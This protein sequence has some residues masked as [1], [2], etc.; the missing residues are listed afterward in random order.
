MTISIIIGSNRENS[1]SARVGRF[2]AQNLKKISDKIQVESI[3]LYLTPLPLFDNTDQSKNLNVAQTALKLLQSDALVVISPE[4]KGSIPPALKNFFCMFG[5]AEFGHKPGLIVGVSSGRGGAF[6]VN[7]LRSTNYKNNHICYIPEQVI[8][9]QINDLVLDIEAK[10]KSEV[11]DFIQQRFEYSLRVL[12]EYSAALATVR[13]S[14]VID[15]AK[16]SNGM[17]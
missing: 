4:W 5:N 3:D 16:F 15:F 9:R 14:G 10:K 13:H 2:I 12:L 17:S 6:P 7:E 11:E 8:V 1:E